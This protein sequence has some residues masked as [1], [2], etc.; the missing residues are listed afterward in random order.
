MDL[1]LAKPGSIGNDAQ[2][3]FTCV[4]EG[5]QP[6]P[7]AGDSQY[8]PSTHLH[9]SWRA[10]IRTV[11]HGM[12]LGLVLLNIFVGS[13]DGIKH[14]VSEFVDNSKLSTVINHTWK[15]PQQKKDMYL[16]KHV[17]NMATKMIKGMEHLSYEDRLRELGL[18][19]LEKIRLQGDLRD[20]SST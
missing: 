10:V 12:V 9:N 11:P 6:P 16:L 15:G 20:L 17:Q 8:A 3:G 5:C 2:M 4:Y 7:A 18:F 19:S 14:K 1:P 13:M